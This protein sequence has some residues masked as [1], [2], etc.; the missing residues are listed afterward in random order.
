MKKAG[1]LIGG[2][3]AISLNNKLHFLVLTGWANQNTH[4]NYMLNLFPD[5]K[6]VAIPEQDV[7]NLEGEQFIVENSWRVYPNSN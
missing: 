1:G 4:Q 7:V 3:F 5:L 2:E 6:K